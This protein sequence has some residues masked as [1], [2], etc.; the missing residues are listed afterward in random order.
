MVNGMFPPPMIVGRKDHQ[1]R[2]VADDVIRKFR[3]GEGSMAAIVHNDKN[4]NDPEAGEQ[5]NAKGK[6]V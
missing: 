2:N 4:T 3:L 1:T 6:S 5:C